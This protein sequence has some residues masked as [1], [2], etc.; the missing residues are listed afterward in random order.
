[1]YTVR[2]L[3]K[4]NINVFI[5]DVIYTSVNRVKESGVYRYFQWEGLI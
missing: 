3:L 1:M 5:I 2:L 4:F